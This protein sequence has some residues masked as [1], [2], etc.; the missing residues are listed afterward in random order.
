MPVYLY[1]C[2]EHTS[3]VLPAEAVSNPSYEAN[4]LTNDTYERKDHR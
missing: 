2:F 4:P 3:T 1:E